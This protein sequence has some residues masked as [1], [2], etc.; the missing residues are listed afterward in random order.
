MKIS[1]THCMLAL[2]VLLGLPASHAQT[3]ANYPNRPVTFIVPY[4]P[5][6]GIDIVARTIGPRLSEKWGQPV[7]VDNK[8]GA[9]GNIGAEAVARSAPNGY[10]LMVNAGTL[11]I[12]P[13]LFRN[14]PYDVA[15][16]FT[17]V[18][19]LGLAGNAL[20]VNP[21]VLPAGD[22]NAFLA[23]VRSNQGKLYYSS[24]GNGT[25]HHLGMEF[26]KLRLGLQIGHVP[27]KG[28]A[29]AM[30]DLLGGQVQMMFTLV[31]SALP[32]TRAGKLRVLAV[33]G[34]GRTPLMPE[35]PTFREQGIDFMDGLDAWYG[36]LG[37]AKLPPD[38]VARLNADSRSVIAV[39]AVREILLKQGIVPV[40]STPEELAALI[41]AE[42]VS[43]AKLVQD[44]KI[45]LD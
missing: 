7:V 40:T 23:A 12:T 17:P 18:I 20:V 9:S 14:M 11:T 31:P 45:S 35:A 5:G 10:T 26:L 38:I 39:P 42:L 43:W 19:K 34:T 15:N 33:T 8:P 37:P 2:G 32:Q 36:L 13:A 29:G 24:P 3:G 30:T 1:T 27:Y 28:L 6:T 44:A 16:D 4:S 22:F 21:A 41:K 25:P